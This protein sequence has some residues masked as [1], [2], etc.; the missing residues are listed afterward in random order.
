MGKWYEPYIMIKHL[1]SSAFLISKSSEFNLI[2][3][4]FFPY[5]ELDARGEGSL[6][7]NETSRKRSRGDNYTPF[8]SSHFASEFR[9]L[10]VSIIPQ[11]VIV[12]FLNLI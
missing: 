4:L 6:S 8:L 9:K 7:G 2:Y 11:L 3:L 1:C 12:Y 10:L 5:L